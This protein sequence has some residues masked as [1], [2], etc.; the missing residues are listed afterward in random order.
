[1]TE[2]VYLWMSHHL[3]LQLR[4]IL[5]KFASAHIREHL[6]Y[7]LD[8]V[9]V[10]SGQQPK[11]E[12]QTRDVRAQLY[13]RIGVTNAVT[14]S[15]SHSEYCY[16]QRLTVSTVIVNVSQWVLSLST[17]HSE[18]C[19]C[20]RLT[21]STVIVNVSQWVQLLSTSHSEYCYCQH[22]PVST[23]I[24]NVS[25]WVL[26]LSTSHSEYCHCQRLTVSTVIVNVSQWVLLL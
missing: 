4:E 25:Q 5:P 9:P 23:V 14:S 11:P 12:R 2:V 7:V 1:M 26:S 15:T 3:L 13:S 20:Q 18:Y 17:S 6:L 8:N 22:L 24:V 16:C 19:H 21:V 10:D